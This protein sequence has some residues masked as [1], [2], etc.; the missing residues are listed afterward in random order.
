MDLEEFVETLE[1]EGWAYVLRDLDAHVIQHAIMRD[2][3]IRLQV[4]YEDVIEIM[5]DSASYEDEDE[6]PELDFSDDPF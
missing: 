2:A 4:L 3:V 5:S 6:I 1:R